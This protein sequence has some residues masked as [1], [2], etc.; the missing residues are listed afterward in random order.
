MHTN[1]HSSSTMDGTTVIE[2]FF[3]LTQCG[4]GKRKDL[5]RTPN[6]QEWNELFDI[7]KK[8]ALPGIAFAGIE[9]L[10]QEQRPT[11]D[12]LLQWYKLS[13]IIKGKN[14]TLDKRCALISEKFKSEGFK[15]CILKGQGI[16]RLYPN[17]A[18]RTPGDIDI[19][20]DGGDEKAIEYVKRFFPECEPTYHHVKFPIANGL[21]IEI[22]YRPTWLYNPFTNRRL[23][24]FFEENAAMQFNN[25][26]TTAEGNFSAPTVA[27]NHVYILLH[28][29]R[30]VFFEGIGMRQLLDYYFVLQQG[31]SA[32]EKSEYIVLLKRFG[33]M[34]FAKGVMYVL[35]RMFGLDEEHT[36]VEPN[37]RHGEFL[38]REIMIAG[39]F[40]KYDHR[41]NL[42]QQEYSFKRAVE[43]MRRTMTLA[44]RYPGETF[45]SP[46]FKVWHYF[47]RKS[48]K[49]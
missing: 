1:N 27:F 6:A 47:W 7:A 18:L 21:D 49:N 44:T 34:K 39:N 31:M 14:S 40:G 5:P 35:Q 37:K 43:T 10:P 9:V 8:Q 15:N 29:Y 28:I 25:D 32:N 3:A 17:P 36:P 23:Q 11:K 13:T 33:L 20:L 24:R 26:I 38:L 45:W 2:L 22:H 42:G 4:I 16:A 19:W 46:W 48:H 30:H 12:I 41:Y